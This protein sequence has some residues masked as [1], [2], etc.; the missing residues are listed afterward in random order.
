M[1][2][3]NRPKNW[4]EWDIVYL[5]H[6]RDV[7][8]RITCNCPISTE[9]KNSLVKAQQD[10]HKIVRHLNIVN[11]NLT[12]EELNKYFDNKTMGNKSLTGFASMRMEAFNE[13]P[14]FQ[15][16]WMIKDWRALSQ[17][18]ELFENLSP[19][20]ETLCL[21]SEDPHLFSETRMSKHELDSVLGHYSVLGAYFISANNSEKVQKINDAVNSLDKEME[22]DSDPNMGM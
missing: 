20:Y 5:I 10:L 1:Q 3:N 9:T 21:F 4:L 6:S 16:F 13:N 15:D 2:E 17:N 7:A 8:E 18:L 22:A 11:E 14:N 12:P 19:D